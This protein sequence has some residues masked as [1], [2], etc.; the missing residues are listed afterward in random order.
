[1]YGNYADLRD[2]ERRVGYLATVFFALAIV[3]TF[4]S[5]RIGH[6]AHKY[7]DDSLRAR[8]FHLLGEV[9][10]VFGLWAALFLIVLCFTSSV[11]DVVSYL[12]SLNFTEPAFVFVIMTISATRPVLI[13]AENMI[14]HLARILPMSPSASFYWA[15]LTAGPILGSF[16]T[17]PAAITVTAMI[18]LKSFM[19]RDVSPRF[20]YATLA[21]LLVNISIG[22]TLTHFAAPPVL[23]V[24]GTWNWGLSFM[25][26]HFGYKSMLATLLI[27]SYTTWLIRAEL[28]GIEW[29]NRKPEKSD[30]KPYP[31]RWLAATH[32]AFLGATVYMA[33]HMA[34]FVGIFLLF[35]GLASV[36]Q[37]YQTSLQYDKSLLVALFLGGLVVLGGP[38]AWW[39]TPILQGVSAEFLF[40]STTLLTGITDN[41]ALT[42]LGSQVPDLAA[43]L[44]FA[45]V[46]GAVTGGGLTVI[47][48]APNPAAFAI[49]KKT[50]RDGVISSG[51][52]LAF[53]L[54][55]TVIAALCLW[56]LPSL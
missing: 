40:I 35:M 47:A 37:L 16:I 6:L 50:F 2:R 28:R 38:Q 11:A 36:T 39:I 26:S 4:V 27:A 23:M 5:S 21:A 12:E 18:L 25:F 45:L 33:H 8:L 54:P 51:G 3:H 7:P 31:P 42:Y 15:T 29:D 46:A 41:A 19:G 24:A 49:L 43:R 10:I 53:A 44:K 32:I 14:K 22:G 48:N 17:E 56:F 34:V 13:T 52:L 55:P 30:G 9:E 20:R 1:M